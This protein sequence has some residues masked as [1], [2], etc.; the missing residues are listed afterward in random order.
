MYILNSNVDDLNNSNFTNNGDNDQRLGGAAYFKDSTLYL[1][2]SRFANNT[3]IN[4][5]AIYFSCITAQNCNLTLIDIRFTKNAAISKGGALYYDYVRP[6][7]NGIKFSDNI[8]QYGSDIASCPVRIKFMN[9][10]E[11]EMRLENGWARNCI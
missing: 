3:A 7:K 10:T 9:S 2:N 8:A 6:S 1:Q 11:N 5:G 4:G